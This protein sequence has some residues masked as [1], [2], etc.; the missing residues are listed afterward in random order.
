MSP[1][2]ASAKPLDH[3]ADIFSLGVMLYDMLAGTRPF[4]AEGKPQPLTALD[5]G[6]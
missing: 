5:S 2:Q 3:R 1:E 4:R 6:R